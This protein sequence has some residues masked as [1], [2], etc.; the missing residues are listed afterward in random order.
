MT[1]YYFWFGIF[2]FVGYLIATD[3]SVAYAVVLVSKIVKFQYEK[4]KWWVLH[5]PANPVVKWLMWR[6]AL[7]LAKEL[8]KEFKK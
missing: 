3:E 6:R 7:R 4:T 5:N 8:E 1:S 2:M